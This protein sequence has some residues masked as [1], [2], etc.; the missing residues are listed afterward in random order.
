MPMHPDTLYRLALSRVYKVGPILTRTLLA[1]FGSAQAVFEAR[2]KELKAIPGLSAAT[3]A[4][5]KTDTPHL[6]AER[7]IEY[8]DRN[9]IRIFYYLDEDYPKRFEGTAAAPYLFYFKGTADLN[10]KRSVAIVGTRSP[11]TKGIRQTEHLLT[12]LKEYQPLVVS[13]LAYGIDIRAHRE[14][15]RQAMPT[16]GVLGSGLGK[17][18]PDTH[19][20]VAQ[21]M[22]EN[23]GLLTT[24]PHWVGPERE[25]FPARNRVVAMLADLV[26]VV[27]SDQ[28]GGSIIT[29]NMA[30]E[31]GTPVAAFPGRFDDRAS[32]GCNMLIRD[33]GARLV[34]AAEDVA[35]YLQWRKSELHNRQGH[36]FKELSPDEQAVVAQL[37]EQTEVEVD[38]MR[39]G[40]G[41]PAVQLAGRLLEMELKGLV[42][43]LPGN[44]YRLAY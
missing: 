38:A 21:Q 40:L 44:R 34:T 22:M 16:I 27:E 15:L 31:L 9:N 26:V 3:L 39:R 4:S 32:A 1:H 5:F 2:P 13:G 14:A 19:V 8:A 42:K 17:I 11:T 23:G 37:S 25:H 36:L 7:I 41:W 20:Q 12:G 29:A 30:K 24:H 33:Q 10:T 43:V 6:E 18:Y 28:R 35:H